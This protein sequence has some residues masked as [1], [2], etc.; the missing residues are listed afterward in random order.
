MWRL[1]VGH[2]LRYRAWD[3]DDLA[4]V[5]HPLSGD[6]HLVDASALELLKL[7]ADGPRSTESLVAGLPAVLPDEDQPTLCGFVDS[8][9]LQL[10]GIGLVSAAPI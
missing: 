8:T 7:L 5:Y 9:L 2:A 6:T 4:V 1:A 10:Q 3:T